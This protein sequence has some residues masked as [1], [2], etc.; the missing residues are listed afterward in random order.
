MTVL[1]RAK[2]RSSMVVALP[3]RQLK[4]S[5]FPVRKEGKKEKETQ[6]KGKEGKEMKEREGK[7]GKERRE[8]KRVENWGRR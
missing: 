8:R 4:C 7:K 6:G 3:G 5:N 2:K 1:N